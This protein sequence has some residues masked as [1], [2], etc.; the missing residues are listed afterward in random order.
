[1][2]M[3]PKLQQQQVGAGSYGRVGSS[4]EADTF[5][6]LLKNPFSSW[7]LGAGP[8]EAIVS[9]SRSSVSLKK[10]NHL[11]QKPVANT[12]ILATCGGGRRDWD[13]ENH[14]SRP[15]WAKKFMRPELSWKK[16]S[17]AV[18]ASHPSY[19][20]KPTIGLQFRQV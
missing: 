5:Q 9:M 18:H 8:W 15:A 1:V 6:F 17:V 7:A 10:K 4:K 19:H 14:G 16:L 20:R 11:S 13:G 2:K 12:I 3:E